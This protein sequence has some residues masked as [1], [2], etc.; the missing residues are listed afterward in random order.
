MDTSDVFAGVATHV[1]FA[2]G[3]P[4]T[5]DERSQLVD[6]LATVRIS[7]TVAA[8]S[9]IALADALGVG[10]PTGPALDVV[11]GDMDS[12]DPGRLERASAEGSAVERFP[13]DKDATDLELALDDAAAHAVPGDRLVVVG[14]TS[15]RFDHVL[16]TLLVLSA[17]A[18]DAFERDAWLGGESIHVVQGARLLRLGAGTTFSVLPVHG[19]ALG[20]TARGVRWELHAEVLPAGTS[21]GVSN[22]AA[23]DVVGIEVADGTVLVVVPSDRER[24]DGTGG[25]DALQIDDAEEAR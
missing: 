6:R 3:P 18:Y 14:T 5:P 10:A 7:R 19:D 16:S 17:P 13:A 20:V 21:R 12:V 24:P 9:G 2:G 23:R 1:V 25:A 4:P 22:V 15:G 8:D 11:L